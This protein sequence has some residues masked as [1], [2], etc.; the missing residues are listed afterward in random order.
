MLVRKPPTKSAL[1]ETLLTE[2]SKLKAAW[3][4]H[5]ASFLDTY[6]VQDVEDPRINI[7]SILT[8]H[9]LIKELFGNRYVTIMENEVYFALVVN[10]LLGQLKSSQS[11]EAI[12]R[13]T[14][15]ILHELLAEDIA[16]TTHSIPPFIAC[17]FGKLGFPNYIGDLLMWV[18]RD[19]DAEGIPEYLLNIF[20][21][22][23][24]ET[25]AEEQIDPIRVLEA[26]CGSSNDYRF[27]EWYGLARFLHYTG[28]DLSEKNIRNAKNRFPDIDFQVGSVFD[29]PAED[30]T[31]DVC[32]VH[33]LFEH[34][35]P[36]GIDRAVGEICRVTGR[37]ACLHFFNMAET[38]NDAIQTKGDYYWNRLSCQRMHKR[39]E[40]SA[41]RVENCSLDAWLKT[42]YAYSNFYNQSAYT[43]YIDVDTQASR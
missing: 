21:V 25:L 13:L 14:S 17:A 6:L 18:P 5:N 12:D 39:L 15:E 3:Q 26:G 31:Y 27:L 4:R 2:T 30:Q 16:P 23:W 35:S 43:W 24:A 1:S 29:L 40:P 38:P 33:D 19:C 42:Q 11:R 41:C 34:L 28:I 8:R 32:F 9:F 22:I 7:Q 37:K 10:W 20:Q 36:E